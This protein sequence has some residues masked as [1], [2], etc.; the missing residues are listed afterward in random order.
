MNCIQNGSVIW[1]SKIHIF[2]YEGHISWVNAY[3][4]DYCLATA[5][6]KH[7]ESEYQSWTPYLLSFRDI[8]TMAHSFCLFFNTPRLWYLYTNSIKANS[9]SCETWY[10][11]TCD[12][13]NNS[14]KRSFFCHFDFDLGTKFEDSLRHFFKLSKQKTSEIIGNVI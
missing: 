2:E 13:L 9:R 1:K 10:F 7:L 11:I 12:F 6:L 14:F 8:I 5:F 4:G 3:T